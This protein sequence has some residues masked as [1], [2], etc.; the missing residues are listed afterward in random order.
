MKYL[1]LFAAKLVVQ[2][3]EDVALIVADHLC[4]LCDTYTQMPDWEMIPQTLTGV[5]PTHL[6]VSLHVLLRH[7]HNNGII[8]MWNPLA[9]LA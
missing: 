3:A 6:A 9:T 8:E 2:D 7:T 4:I 5:A 1:Q